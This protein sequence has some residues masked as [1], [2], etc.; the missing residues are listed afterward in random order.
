[1]RTVTLLRLEWYPM[2]AV[3]VLGNYP[4]AV[5]LDGFR[6]GRQ[7]LFHNIFSNVQASA[8]G[9]IPAYGKKMR[10][11]PPCH[12]LIVYVPLP[13]TRDCASNFHCHCGADPA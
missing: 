10:F 3:F 2:T 1:M 7:Q 12:T 9:S 5:E 11:D 4:L 8:H 13:T 6:T